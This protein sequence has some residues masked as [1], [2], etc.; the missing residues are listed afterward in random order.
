[1]R[2]L[3]PGELGGMT[4]VLDGARDWLG[5]KEFA[6]Q[7]PEIGQAPESVR[8]AGVTVQREIRQSK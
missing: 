6:D 5:P 7:Y 8:F 4:L 1:M 3:E 2:K